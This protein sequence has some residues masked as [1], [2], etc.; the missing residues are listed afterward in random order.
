MTV[1]VL[2]KCHESTTTLR[3]LLM[4]STKQNSTNFDNQEFETW[5]TVLKTKGSIRW[6]KEPNLNLLLCIFQ[7]ANVW[8]RISRL[9]KQKNC[10]RSKSFP[11]SKP[12]HWRFS[13]ILNITRILLDEKWANRFSQILNIWSIF[14]VKWGRSIISWNLYFSVL[15]T[16]MGK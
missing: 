1:P 5:Q 12:L 3:T 4:M 2:L 16:I 15:H 14:V 10:I 9:L 7:V 11:Y 6:K 8:W 13:Q